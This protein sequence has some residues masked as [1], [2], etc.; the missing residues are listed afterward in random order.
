MISSLHQMQKKTFLK[1]KKNLNDLGL[2]KLTQEFFFD[3]K[4]SYSNLV[5]KLKYLNLSKYLRVR[6]W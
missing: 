1:S 5:I 4:S 2:Y 3:L 6:T